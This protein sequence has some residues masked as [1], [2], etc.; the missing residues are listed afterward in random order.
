MKGTTLFVIAVLLALLA[1]VPGLAGGQGSATT[2]NFQGELAD[3][4]GQPLNGSYNLRFAIY[5]A[6]SGGNRIWPTSAEHEEHDVDISDGLFSVLLGS[7]GHP[8]SAGQFD[9]R[10][11]YLQ[12]WVSPGHALGA[13]SSSIETLSPR[14]A[15][16]SVP[17]TLYAS[18]AWALVGNAGTNPAANFLG[19]TD[20][21]PFVVRVQNER[22][23]TIEPMYDALHNFS[24]NL[25][26][27]PNDVFG[28]AYGATIGGGG[29]S[30]YPNKVSSTYGTISG[31]GENTVGGAYASIGGGQANA[32]DGRHATIGGGRGNVSG[33]PITT[34]AGG[35][36]NTA[37]G[38]AAA[39]GGGGG[40]R[41]NGEFATVSGGAAHVA[42]GGHAT[43]SGGEQN[44]ATA[45]HAT[46]S[47]GLGNEV[48]G[49]Y[50]A[51]GGGEHNTITATHATVSGG[52][53]NQA[54]G[55]HVAIGGGEGNAATAAHAAVSGGKN[56]IATAAFAAISGGQTNEAKGIHSGIGGG[57]SNKATGEYAAIGG[58][59]LNTASSNAPTIGGG[60][61][62]SAAFYCV[63]GGGYENTA[64]F[65]YGTVGGGHGN[66]A[67]GEGSTVGGGMGNQASLGPSTVSGGSSNAALYHYA[68]IGGGE[69]NLITAT[70]ATISGGYENKATGEYSVVGGGFR[71]S[72]RG[73][74]ATVSGGWHNWATGGQ[75]GAATIGGGWSNEAEG[76]YATVPG[77]R[78]NSAKGLGSFAAGQRAQADHEGA[79]VWSGAGPFETTSS[80]GD[81]TF[82]VDAHGGARF[83]STAGISM[84]VQLSAGSGSWA[85]VSSRDTKENLK[86]VDAQELLDRLSGI[87]VSS[88]NYKAQ[89]PSIRHVG[90]MADDFNALVQG[91]GGEGEDYINALDADGVALAA[92]QG[93]YHLV[94]EQDAHISVQQQRIDDLEARL[95][96]LEQAAAATGFSASSLPLGGLPFGGL[97][98]VLLGGLVLAAGVGVQRRQK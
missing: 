76:S 50:A 2:I 48:R 69:G 37:G 11:R 16:A 60:Y 12:V 22:A 80:W 36:G 5:D 46:V 67:S 54:M 95:A 26:C 29:S 92:I 91:L 90:P 96:T 38:T 61:K 39:I 1:L 79:F 56:N 10:D 9:G 59:L 4:E 63:V 31:G 85:A 83:Y 35:E 8:L 72:S 30:S 77:G 49:E 89:D 17:H 28:G 75:G 18:G 41:A 97:T 94:Q 98:T 73:A 68:T 15:I 7:Q 64:D 23:L 57:K 14:L 13:Q 51:I 24:P 78:E 65:S 19:T 34:I 44:V 87:E 55:D 86:A 27:G 21:A 70:H 20:N 74:Y 40:N 62:N 93:L 32:A 71:N 88:W 58:G 33:G 3:I 25:I 82:T 66:K 47:G 6:H 52:D 53:G 42:D 84:G 45:A 81:Y 43:V